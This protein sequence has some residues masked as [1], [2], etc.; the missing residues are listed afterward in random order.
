MKKTG[1]KMAVF[2][3]EEA[4]TAEFRSTIKVEESYKF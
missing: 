2:H 4:F 1:Y 3:L